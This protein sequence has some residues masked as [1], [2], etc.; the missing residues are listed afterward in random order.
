MLT[1]SYP[2]SPYS[3]GSRTPPQA[4]QISVTEHTHPSGFKSTSVS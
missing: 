1:V 3:S 4:S 2:S